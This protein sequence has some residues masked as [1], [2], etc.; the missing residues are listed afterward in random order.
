M[1]VTA[2]EGKV[3]YLNAK[4]VFGWTPDYLTRNGRPWFPVMGEFHYS[5]YPDRYWEE[6]LYKMKACGVGVVSTYVIW[7]HHEEEEGRYDFTGCRNLRGFL[8]AADKC[9][10]PVILRI[11]PWCHGEVRNGG[12]PD[13]LLQKEYQPRTNDER[14]FACVE[15]YY[16]RVFEEVQGYLLKDGGP[17]IGVQIENEYGHCGGLNGE[18]GEMH[19]RR[20]KELAQKAGFE[21]PY[22]SATGWG[23]AATGG[24][25]PVLGGYCEAP[26]DQRITEIEPSV[27]YVFTR[28]RNDRNIGSDQRKGEDLTWPCDKFPYLTAELGGGVQVTKHRRPVASAR[29]IGAMTLTK[30]GCGANLL[31]YYMYHGGTNPHGKRSTLQESRETGYPNDLP[32]YSYDFNAPIREYGQISDTALELKLYAMFLHDFGEEFCR[33]DTYLT[34]ENPE[35]P[36]DASR[37]RTAVRRNGRSGYLFVNNYQRRKKLAEHD[38]VTLKAELPGECIQFG[39]Q[40]IHDGDYFFYPF[41]FPVGEKAELLC[42]NATPLCI[43]R[44]SD[45]CRYCFYGEKPDFK[46]KGD[47]EGNALVCLSRQEALHSWKIEAG[48]EEHLIICRY[49]VIKME[50]GYHILCRPKAHE[51]VEIAAYPELAQSPEGFKKS[52]SEG[53]YTVYT[54]SN[55]PK[56]QPCRCKMTEYRERESTRYEVEIEYDGIYREQGCCGGRIPEDVFLKLDYTGESLELFINGSKEGDHFYTGQLWEIGLKRFDFPE[57]V[58]LVIHRLDSNMPIYLEV[59]PDLPDG[60][61]AAVNTLTAEKEYSIPLRF[62]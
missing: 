24:L 62:N 56:P 6:S 1:A 21:V 59:W 2:V 28:E 9:G 25:L 47:L 7:I 23:G 40:D 44:R 3:N 5:R 41:H 54:M 51:A 32:E 16:N 14:Y 53:I 33:M 35:D 48:G 58:E 10:M 60:G 49:P 52:R 31:G 36:N 57:K 4:E 43:L 46:V 15:A 39:T 20:L 26:W 27:N 12:F 61:E 29:D 45:G 38:A 19:M 55:S 8:A 13:W 11:G 22:Y 50:H 30:L 42:A 17:V 37:L 18:A 34:E